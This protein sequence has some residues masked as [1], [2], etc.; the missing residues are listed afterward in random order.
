MYQAG[1]KEWDENYARL[2]EERK[3]SEPQPYIIGTPEWASEFENKIQGDDRYKAAART[4]E[5]SVVLVFKANP[6]AG[7]EDDVFVF[8]DLWHGECHSSR[9]V[10]AEV[11]RTGDYVL[12][13]E[14]ER[15]KKILRKELNV[16]KEIA[17][18]KLKLVPFNVKKAAKLAAATQAAIRL[19]ALAGEVSDKFPDELEVEEF[20]SFKVM[21]KDLKAQFGI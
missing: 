10:P 12:E 2:V 13:A 4:W 15:W 18:L 16:V 17:T 14:Y 6:E 1:T 5:G 20:Q 7:F 3:K 9:I 21:H 11:G 19:V 8:M